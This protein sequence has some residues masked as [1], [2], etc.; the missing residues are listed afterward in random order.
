MIRIPAETELEEKKMPADGYVCRIVKATTGVNRYDE[1]CLL[2]YL[3]VAE[4]DFANYFG[5]IYARRLD[6]GENNYP[7]VLNQRIG[8]YSTKRFNR[9]ITAIED[10]N[11]GYVYTGKEGED[12]DEGELENLLVGVVFREKTFINARGVRRVILVPHEV[13]SVDEI[14]R[15]AFS[16]PTRKYE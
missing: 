6:H 13:K 16:I 4:G 7:C 2:L 8:K 3:D 10:S 5:K 15:G 14:R 11:D 9:L 12:W 1:P